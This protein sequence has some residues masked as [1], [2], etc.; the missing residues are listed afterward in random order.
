MIT[1]KFTTYK[2][3]LT[4]GEKASVNQVIDILKS[5]SKDISDEAMIDKI[6]GEPLFSED[7]EYII[8]TL[9]KFKD[10]GEWGLTQNT[11]VS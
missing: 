11:I 7:L 2:V 9:Y 8:D 10:G 5:I 1:R 4:D 3:M 6:S